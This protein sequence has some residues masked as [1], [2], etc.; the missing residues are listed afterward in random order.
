MLLNNYHSLTR[1]R[2]SRFYGRGRGSGQRRRGGRRRG[3]KGVRRTFTKD[4]GVYRKSVSS[5]VTLRFGVKDSKHGCARRFLL[6]TTRG[7]AGH[8]GK[9]NNSNQIGVFRTEL[10]LRVRQYFHYRSGASK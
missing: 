6:R 10:V 3:V 5:G 8:V 7:I 9:A 1:Q 2:V 4:P